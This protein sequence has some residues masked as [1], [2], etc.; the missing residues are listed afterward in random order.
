MEPCYQT[1]WTCLRQIT[2]ERVRFGSASRVDGDCFTWKFLL[3]PPGKLV[4]FVVASAHNAGFD[5]EKLCLS[6]NITRLATESLNLVSGPLVRVWGGGS[7]FGG[8]VAGVAG[9]TNDGIDG[10]YIAPEQSIHCRAS[11]SGPTADRTRAIDLAGQFV[12]RCAAV[13]RDATP[14]PKLARTRGRRRSFRAR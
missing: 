13:S 5:Q 11:R 7:S 4:A 3:L 8:D 6:S 9:V 10:C 2:L 1:R 14:G 12:K